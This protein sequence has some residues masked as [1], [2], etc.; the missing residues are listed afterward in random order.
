[1]LRPHSQILE[2]P[3]KAVELLAKNLPNASIFFLTYIVANGFAGSASALAQIGPLVVHVVKKYLFGSTP[4]QSFEI[5]FM[6][7]QVGSSAIPSA[8]LC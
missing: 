3:S 6:M 4:R 5:T 2:Q 7:P 1:L 8:K